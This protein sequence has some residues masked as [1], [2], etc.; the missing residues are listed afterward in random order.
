MN[1]YQLNRLLKSKKPMA[2]WFCLHNIE[3]ESFQNKSLHHPSVLS[4]VSF[5]LSAFTRFVFPTVNI[6]STRDS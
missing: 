6:H 2:K 1:H 3:L 5:F 4:L